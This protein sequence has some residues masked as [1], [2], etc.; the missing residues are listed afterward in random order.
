MIGVTS[1]DCGGAERFFSDFFSRYKEDI[2]VSHRLYF[3]CDSDTRRNVAL[4][5]KLRTEQ[6]VILL[7]NW[8]NRLKNILEP[9][10]FIL[11]ILR[12]RIRIV[13]VTS[14]TVA[15]YPRISWISRIPRAWRPKLVLT[16]VD[17]LVPHILRDPAHPK[18][19]HYVDKYMPFFRDLPVNAVL[20]WY[21]AFVDYVREFSPF[22]K[23]P[24]LHAISCR[25]ADVDAATSVDFE[26]KAPVIVWAARLTI[27]K[28]P[29]MFLAALKQLKDCNVH[30]G[31]WSFE[32]YG[33]GELTYEVR[34]FIGANG[35]GEIVSYHGSQVLDPVFMRSKCFVSTQDHEN[36]PSLSMMEAMQYGN[37]VISRN[38]GQTS[39]LVK[40][41]ANGILL[42]EDTV[43]GLVDAIRKF[44]DLQ[45]V[46]P[47]MAYESVRLMTE[48]HNYEN[49]RKEI[50]QFWLD[51]ARSKERAN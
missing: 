1:R 3:F 44:I 34:S 20:S 8:S 51:V 26:R 36:F 29:L 48:V 2:S 19:A 17:C 31:E 46:H 9:L 5:G 50:D 16:I 38:V 6:D 32:M 21:W 28:R 43:S 24:L 14:Y 49:F 47:K 27:E 4:L 11:K 40:D 12:H 23:L 33:D 35:L 10:Q 39:L 45:V 7:R 18:H 13:H 42:A 30:L 25:Y 37:A 41:G 15:F 22:R